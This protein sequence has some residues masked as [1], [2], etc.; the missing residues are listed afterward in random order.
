[1]KLNRGREPGAA[2]EERDSTFTGTVWS[3]PVLR[4]DDGV[5]INTVI[6][7]AGGRTH[8]HS[9]ERGQIL[10]VTHGCGYVQVRDG[11]GDWIG[12]GDVVHFPPGEEHWHGAG[13]ESYMSHTAISL[14]ATDWL[15][16][17]SADEYEASVGRGS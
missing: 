4:T 13:P 2:S 12:P 1:M 6:F 3:D 17:V 16:E 7:P 10:L 14:G 5:T 15:D 11:E 8:W 9:H